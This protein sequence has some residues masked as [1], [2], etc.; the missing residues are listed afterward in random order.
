MIHTIRQ[1]MSSNKPCVRVR[2]KA[3]AKAEVKVKAKAKAKPKAH[4]DPMP[5][6]EQAGLVFDEAGNVKVPEEYYL[7]GPDGEQLNAAVVPNFCRDYLGTDH[8]ELWSVFQ[9]LDTYP[10]DADLDQEFEECRPIKLLPGSHPALKYRGKAIAR[11]KF[12]VQSDFDKG[13]LRYRYTGWQ[14]RTALAQRSIEELPVVHAVLDRLNTVMPEKYRVNHVIGT[15]YKDGKDNIGKHSDKT[16]DFAPG[17]GFI[18]IKLG[19]ARRFQFC[20]LSDN[21][22]YDERLTPGTAVIVGASANLAT[23]HAV[24]P[25]AGVGPSSSLVFR[26]IA[27]VVPWSTVKSK[28]GAAN[29]KN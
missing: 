1:I 13:M 6:Q 26:R 28:I 18:V 9:D 23:K 10:D 24:P 20:D 5:D 21:V 29:Y 14:W 12:W 15:I 25:D 7:T 27:K 17:S 19:C 3:K 2:V 4:P 16:A 11:T 8:E 22:F